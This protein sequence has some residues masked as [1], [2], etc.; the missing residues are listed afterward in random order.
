MQAAKD[1]LPIEVTPSPIVT[2]NNSKQFKKAFL[3]I[4]ITLFGMEIEV[5]P[6]FWKALLPMDNMLLGMVTEVKLVQPDKKLS[7]RE[8]ILLEI[9]IEVRLVQFWNILNNDNHLLTC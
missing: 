1:L 7:L 4:D 2:D 6:L 8:V 3:S 9:V 5:R